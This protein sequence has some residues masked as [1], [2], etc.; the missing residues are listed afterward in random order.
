MIEQQPVPGIMRDGSTP[1]ATRSSSSIARSSIDSEF[2][3]LLVPNTASPQ[4][5]DSNHLQSAMNRSLSGERSVLNGVTT[6]ASTPRMRRV[7][8]SR[9]PMNIA[10][11]ETSNLPNGQIDLLAPAPFGLSA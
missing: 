3:S 5:C 11:T 8:V 7:M 6:G 10:E 4:F 9:E 2:A 1:A